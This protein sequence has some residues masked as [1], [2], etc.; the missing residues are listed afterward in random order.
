MIGPFKKAQ[1]RYTHILVTID[2]FIMWI[3][4]KTIVALT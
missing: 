1:G 2:K 4:Y 3:E